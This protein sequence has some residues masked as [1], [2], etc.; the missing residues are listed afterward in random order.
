MDMSSERKQ[1]EK[2][3][4]K[5]VAETAATTATIVVSGKTIATVLDSGIE[6]IREVT[7]EKSVAEPI[8]ELPQ[9]EDVSE[10]ETGIKQEEVFRED[11]AIANVVFENDDIEVVPKQNSVSVQETDNDTEDVTLISTEPLSEYAPVGDNEESEVSEDR[12]DTLETAETEENCMEEK[13][14]CTYQDDPVSNT[15]EMGV[16]DNDSLDTD[17][18]SDDFTTM[19]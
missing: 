13:P 18:I 11:G 10:G 4:I 7:Q 19:A 16:S 5:V 8:E 1:N 6:A 12:V 14:D 2:K 9:K 15:E 17:W 3:G